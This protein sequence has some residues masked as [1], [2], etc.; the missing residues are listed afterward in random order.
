MARSLHQLLGIALAATIFVVSCAPQADVEPQRTPI[1][2]GSLQPYQT[3]SP[4]AVLLTATPIPTRT[5]LPTPTAHLYTVQSGETMGSIAL[6]FG[7]DMGDLLNANP[8]VSPYAM[9]VG[10]QLVIPNKEPASVIVAVNPLPILFA[11]PACHTTLSGGMWCF[12]LVQ[13]NLKGVVEGIS[14]D[15]QVYD[16]TGAL[17]TH[18]KAF[19]LL[20]RLPVGETLPAGVYF[21]D[22]PTERQV[23]AELLTAFEGT[24]DD[25][26]YLS[27]SLTGV[28]TQIAWDG[29]SAKVSGQVMVDGKAE[30]VWVLATAFDAADQVVGVRRWGSNAGGQ[31]FE[32]RVASLGPEIVRVSLSAEAKR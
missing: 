7:L 20:D 26:N 3:P 21:A 14:F 2:V 29:R 32:I 5:P 28:L 19:P 22:V 18:R 16:N 24:V 4:S 11:D 30:H 1:L 10:Q 31:D 27:A 13:N 23:Y 8:D 6:D 17:F 25:E 12:V 15:V 9:S